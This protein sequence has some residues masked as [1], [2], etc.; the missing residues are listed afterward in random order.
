[1]IIPYTTPSGNQRKM[2]QCH[3]AGWRFMVSP[4]DPGRTLP[5]GARWALDNGAWSAYRQH[6]PFDEGA[7]LAALA[8][9]GTGADFVVVPDVVAGGVL[10]LARSEHWLLHRLRGQLP[11][12][13]LLLV[14]VQDGME[15]Q[16]LRPLLEADPQTGLFVGGTDPW[17][18]MMLA[19]WCELGQQLGRWVH[20]GRVNSWRRV[21]RVKCAGAASFDG[22]GPGIYTFDQPRR[23]SRLSLMDGAV[24]QEVL[25]L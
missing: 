9:W 12:R 24:R 11:P 7:F 13:T 19:G 20:V 4:L 8:Q 18:A 2:A 21:V 23:R 3:A 17:R 1:M 10:S 25:L 16:H 14:P 22:S 6:R 15:E 5:A